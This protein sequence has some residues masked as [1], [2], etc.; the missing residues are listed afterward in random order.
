MD[1]GR[2]RFAERNS[3]DHDSSG[4]PV[5]KQRGRM[6]GGDGTTATVSHADSST[7]VATTTT[8]DNSMFVLVGESAVPG[9]NTQ[10]GN[11]RWTYAKPH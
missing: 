10:T 6:G 3:I 9:V 11:E 1:T 2:G 8:A 5:S 7:D 4:D